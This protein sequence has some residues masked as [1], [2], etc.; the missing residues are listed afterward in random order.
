MS[1]WKEFYEIYLPLQRKYGLMYTSCENN[2]RR[3]LVIRQGERVLIN[4][5]TEDM[6]MDKVLDHVIRDMIFYEQHGFFK[7]K[8]SHGPP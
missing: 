2:R 3:S 6:E 5:T 8:Y 1:P 4:I 7:K